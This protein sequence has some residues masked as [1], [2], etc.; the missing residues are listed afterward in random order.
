MSLPATA[1]G[2]RIIGVGIYE[3]RHEDLSDMQLELH[4]HQ[5]IDRLTLPSVPFF[6]QYRHGLTTSSSNFGRKA[7]VAMDVP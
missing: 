3:V 1:V 4:L 6:G 7:E 2:T 5:P